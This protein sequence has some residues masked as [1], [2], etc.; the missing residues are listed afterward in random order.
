MTLKFLGPRV[1]G[2]PVM[3]L[4]NNTISLDYCLHNKCLNHCMFCW[5]SD[6]VYT[7]LTSFIWLF[8]NIFS[9]FHANIPYNNFTIARYSIFIQICNSDRLK[10]TFISLTSITSLETQT[11]KSF[12]FIY[13]YPLYKSKPN[14]CIF[15]SFLK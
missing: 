6:Y 5:C 12:E 14:I 2:G 15:V 1:S 10:F 13:L 8:L 4:S 11:I 3:S 9:P 7:I